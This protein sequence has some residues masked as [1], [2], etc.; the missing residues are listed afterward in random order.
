METGRGIVRAGC[1][2]VSHVYKMAARGGL[3]RSHETLGTDEPTAQ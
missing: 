2:N 1:E 3:V